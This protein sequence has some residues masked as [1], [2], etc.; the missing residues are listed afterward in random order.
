MRE[1]VFGVIGRVSVNDRRAVLRVRE[2]IN[3]RA[4]KLPKALSEKL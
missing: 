1:R 4:F 2:I 3:A